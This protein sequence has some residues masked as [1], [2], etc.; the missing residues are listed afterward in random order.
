MCSCGCDSLAVPT[1]H[2]IV[3]EV[4]DSHLDLVAEEPDMFPM[5][6]P[7][8][9]TELKFSRWPET[10]LQIYAGIAFYLLDLQLLAFRFVNAGLRYVA[11]FLIKRN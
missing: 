1:Q 8:L 6:K 9:K 10:Q 7:E 4:R 3:C 11:L 2:Q 5:I